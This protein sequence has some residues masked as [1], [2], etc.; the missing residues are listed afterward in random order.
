MP[1][2]GAPR[3]SGPSLAVPPGGCHV[4]PARP[5][6]LGRTGA[7]LPQAPC[8]SL[9]DRRAEEWPLRTR[10]VPG[11][12]RKPR[13]HVG[14]RPVSPV[15]KRL[16]SSTTFCV[17]RSTWGPSHRR[18]CPVKPGRGLFL[19]LPPRPVPM[20]KTQLEGDRSGTRPEDTAACFHQGQ[21][22][23]RGGGTPGPGQR[24]DIVAAG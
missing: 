7:A 16:A 20:L 6:A 12:Q 8:R 22:H 5:A 17:N 24:P 19:P 11:L 15:R 2:P 18:V 23:L 4:L 10:L 14:H 1:R 3:L 21:C 13:G 9:P